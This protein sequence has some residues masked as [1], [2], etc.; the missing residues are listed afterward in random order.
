V[1]WVGVGFVVACVAACGSLT[2]ASDSASSA[3]DAGGQGEAGGDKGDAGG[4]SDAASSPFCATN[5]GDATVF[6]DDFDEPGRTDVGAGGWSAFQPFP[7]GEVVT[8]KFTSPPQAARFACDGGR[9]GV[10]RTVPF[11]ATA[12]RFTLRAKVQPSS[13]Y[14]SSGDL[15]QIAYSTCTIELYADNDLTVSCDGLSPQTLPVPTVPP[16]Q[17]TALSLGFERTADGLHVFTESGEG[18]TK[19]TND[20]S[21]SVTALAASESAEIR[22]GDLGDDIVGTAWIDDVLVE[23]K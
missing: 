19:I 20:A 8:E 6:C 4:E 14:G 13:P 1:R 3:G 21:F 5:R 23:V 12:T 9:A 7:T 17:F 18:S 22:I 16:G 15:L 2:G 10:R 11:P